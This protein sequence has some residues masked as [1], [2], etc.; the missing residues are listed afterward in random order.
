MA[1][2]EA[3]PVA[4]MIHRYATSALKRYRGNIALVISVPNQ[5]TTQNVQVI[6]A[7]LMRWPNP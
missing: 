4:A 2:E 1:S 5:E 3:N 6:D 7:F